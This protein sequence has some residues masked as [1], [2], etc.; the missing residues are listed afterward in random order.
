MRRVR[1]V[2]T[3]RDVAGPRRGAEGRRTAD[4]QGTEEQQQGGKSADRSLHGDLP[5]SLAETGAYQMVDST[6]AFCFTR[7]STIAWL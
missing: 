1:Q 7:M 4:E 5:P 6:F 3:V 2:R